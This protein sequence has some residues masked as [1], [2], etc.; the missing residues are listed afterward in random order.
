MAI[1]GC[2]RPVPHR[3]RGVPTTLL[4]AAV[5]AIGVGRVW[6][7]EVVDVAGVC[8]GCHPVEAADWVA[9]G[10]HAP[11]L[12]CISCHRDV[13]PNRFGRGHRAIARCT[14]HHAVEG[15][16][17]RRRPRHGRRAQRNCLACHQPH[18]SSNLA[19][20]RPKVRRRRRLIPAVFTDE[21]GAAPGGFTN[22]QAPGTGLCE[23]CHRKTEFFRRDGTGGEHF[24][25][26]CT[27]CHRHETGFAP[28]AVSDES[29]GICHPEQ[30]TRFEKP[31][32]HSADLACIDCHAEQSPEPGPGHRAI[33]VCADCHDNATHAP[34]GPPGFACERC[35]EPHGTDNRT[36]IVE[37]IAVPQGGTRPIVFT[38]LDGRADGSLASESMPGS[39][40]CET[41]HTTTRFYRADG[42][43]EP[44]YDL[45]CL[46]CHLHADGFLPQ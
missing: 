25:A 27:V 2:E 45:F 35:H 18:G 28:V 13:R 17:P 42:T 41:C 5:I 7:E 12:D 36:L 30:A 6:A 9:T 14:S 1:F 4:A 10:G 44:H 31:S 43:G 38:D 46:A 34:E 22:P 19:L 39:G 11:T 3:V 37:E 26:P 23:A 24:T 29:C 33:S 16:P 40:L 8:A 15:H 32:K 21:S 20:V